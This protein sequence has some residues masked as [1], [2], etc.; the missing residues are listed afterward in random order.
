MASA[1]DRMVSPFYTK[2]FLFSAAF[3]AFVLVVGYFISPHEL[4]MID[5]WMLVF[6]LVS[7]LFFPMA[8]KFAQRFS[9]SPADSIHWGRGLAIPVFLLAIPLGLIELFLR[10][11]SVSRKYHH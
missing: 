3:Y 10:K 4:G 9:A 5:I 11:R 6:A 7:S 2:M 1:N 8:Y